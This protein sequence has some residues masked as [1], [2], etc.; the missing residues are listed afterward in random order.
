M[1]LN[2]VFVTGSGFLAD[3]YDLFVINVAVDMM[4]QVQYKEALTDDL[5]SHVKTMAL[6]G[7]VIG[8]IGFGACAD[9]IG[10]RR[11]F[12]ATCTLV[13]FGALMSATVVNSSSFGIYSQ[14]C[15]W[16]FVLGV[17]V[18]GE[19]PLSASITS[20][21]SS[22]ADK[23][24]NLAMV[25]SMQGFGTVLCALVLVTVSHTMG[26]NYNAM[27]RVSLA[28][29]GLPMLIAFYYRWKMSESDAWTI[30][31]TNLT[32]VAS[33]DKI[34]SLTSHEYN[35]ST[36]LYTP[37]LTVSKDFPIDN[38]PCCGNA[39]S[40]YLNAVLENR[41]KL[42]GTAGAWFILDVVF[43]ANGLFSGQLTQAMGFSSSIKREAVGQL[44]LQVL[45]LPGY[46][47]TIIYVEQ[48]GLRNLQL[49]GFLSVAVI[50]SLMACLHGYLREIPSAYIFI[51]GATFFFE[52][53]GANTTT[54]IIPSVLYPTIHTSTCHGISSAMG[55]LGA[56]AGAELLLRL[57]KI[58]G[59]TSVFST[60]A[61]MATLGA[62]WT[63]A[64]IPNNSG[65]NNP[66]REPKI[67][68]IIYPPIHVNK[69][70]NLNKNI[71]GHAAAIELRHEESRVDEGTLTA[72][73]QTE[74]RDDVSAES[75]DMH[76]NVRTDSK[77]S[78]INE[79]PV[80]VH[81]GGAR[82]ANGQPRDSDDD[83]DTV[84][85]DDGDTR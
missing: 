14:L 53:F 56:I 30:A 8:Q 81:A 1:G 49:V 64:F 15:L 83:S 2:K 85:T 55:K 71:D 37:M 63:V 33:V 28:M 51:Y 24:R 75:V 7:A 44:A 40:F 34:K 9:L 57:H 45:A 21:S 43:Y 65:R 73:L 32:S 72:R 18:G 20:E 76:S 50:F 5:K 52:N 25:F 13:I 4:A 77:L 6:V 70:P 84:I 80:P 68:S 16:R 23:V 22:E 41:M 79:L 46:L 11:V 62:A 61:C 48:I 3:A 59:L 36:S 67:H 54:Y 38:T 58:S 66:I 42:L 35:E 60:C 12:I 69:N 47:C 82:R 31:S 26:E 29:G 39:A 19:Y 10:R 74:T 17:G 78:F 27:W